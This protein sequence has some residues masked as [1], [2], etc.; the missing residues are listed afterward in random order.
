MQTFSDADN[1]PAF[2]PIDRELVAKSGLIL[3]ENRR[4]KVPETHHGTKSNYEQSGG[5]LTEF[6]GSPGFVQLKSE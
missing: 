4:G 2:R 5:P 6:W 3:V 1:S